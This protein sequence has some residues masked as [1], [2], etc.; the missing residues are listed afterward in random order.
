MKHQ[1]VL[2]EQVVDALNIKPGGIYL[3]GTVGYGGHAEAI[4][5]AARGSLQYIGLDRDQDALDYT[6]D[7]L[8]KYDNISLHHASYADAKKILDELGI[9]EVD[10]ILLDLGASS[11]QFD[12]PKRGFSLTKDGPLDMRFDVSG[13]LTA[14]DILNT[15]QEKELERILRTYG[16]ER[17]AKK[18]AQA[19]VLYREQEEFT[20]TSQLKILIL[21]R[22]STQIT[23]P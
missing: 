18:I 12:D 3:D 21:F 8:K 20:R 2:I 16:E 14:A 19:I 1:P 17:Y 5:K 7:K 23:F 9:A 4:L 10:G 15:Y 13:K 6:Q 22:L 11:P